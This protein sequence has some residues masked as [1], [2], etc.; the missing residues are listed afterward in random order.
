MPT[1]RGVSDRFSTARLIVMYFQATSGVAAG[2]G[3]DRP[4]TNPGGV[5]SSG[6][7]GVSSTRSATRPSAVAV[8]FGVAVAAALRVAGTALGLLEAEGA[9]A[10]HEITRSSASGLMRSGR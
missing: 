8:G 3:V 9:G 10:A 2:V 7:S 4:A 1:R 6:G 5:G